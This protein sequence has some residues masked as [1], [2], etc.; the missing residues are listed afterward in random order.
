V[1]PAA[2]K[3]AASSAAHEPIRTAGRALAWPRRASIVASAPASSVA[4]EDGTSAAQYA[5]SAK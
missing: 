2:A 3:A 5:E 4:E 1:R